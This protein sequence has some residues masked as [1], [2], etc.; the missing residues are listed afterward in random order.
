ML[1]QTQAAPHAFCRQDTEGQDTEG[2]DTEG[3][4]AEGQ[5]AEGQDAAVSF[6]TPVPT[7]SAAQL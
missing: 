5:D 6:R 4:D 7:L 1:H 3:Q 2:Q